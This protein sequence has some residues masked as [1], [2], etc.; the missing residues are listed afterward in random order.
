MAMDNVVLLPHIGSSTK[1]IRDER[2]RK[3][4]ANLR[5]HF[6]GKPVPYPVVE[7]AK[8]QGSRD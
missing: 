6:A 1:E 5:A 3:L 7:R 2:A 8:A 4:M